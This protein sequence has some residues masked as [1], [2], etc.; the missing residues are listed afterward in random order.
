LISSISSPLTSSAKAIKSSSATSS[1]ISS[2]SA[3]KKSASCVL[4][5]EANEL[6]LCFLLD[7]LVRFLDSSTNTSQDLQPHHNGVKTTLNCLQLNLRRCPVIRL[8]LIPSVD[9]R[10]RWLFC[11]LGIT[12]RV[13]GNLRLL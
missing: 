2:S 4:S 1:S 5:V 12:S 3:P 10:L 13:F 11:Q 7:Y 8:E 6:T 9:D